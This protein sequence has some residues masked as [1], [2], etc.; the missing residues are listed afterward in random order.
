MFGLWAA[1]AAG[2]SAAVELRGALFD[3]AAARLTPIASYQ[4]GL[5]GTGLLAVAD[6]TVLS[7]TTDSRGLARWYTRGMGKFG[8]PEVE[9]QDAPAGLDLGPLLRD[10]AQFLLD[11]LLTA[12]HDRE[13]PVAEL[14]LGPEISLPQADGSA[15]FRIIHTPRQGDL[16]PIVDVL[17]TPGYRGT[18]GAF[19]AAVAAGQPPPSS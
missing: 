4:Q 6:H 14:S 2:R 7:S 3:A 13:Q 1:I 19:L 9:I 16:P 18:Q 12:N 15:R 17:P 10:L 5:P 8:L 11:Q